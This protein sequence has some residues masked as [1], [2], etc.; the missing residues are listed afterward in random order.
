MKKIFDSITKIEEV[1]LSTTVIVM[2]IMLILNVFMR[3]VLNNSFTFTEELGQIMLTIITFMGIGYCVTK[4][5]HI[6]MSAVFDLVSMRGKKIMMLIISSLSTIIMF[7]LAWIAFSYV[8]KMQMMGRVTPALGIP[9]FTYSW[10]IVIGFF[11]GGVGYLRTFIK[12]ITNKEVYVSPE[13]VANDFKA[14]IS[15]KSSN[16]GEVKK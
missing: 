5:K 13:T 8:S 3:V 10:V 7:G 12:N 14:E 9:V 2:A 15:G 11:M 4:A 6:N 1:I 16:N